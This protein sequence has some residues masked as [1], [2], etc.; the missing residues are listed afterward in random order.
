MV[1]VAEA[2]EAVTATDGAAD[3]LGV[4][5]AIADAE[6]A[7]VGAGLLDG[8]PDAVEDPQPATTIAAPA[9]MPISVR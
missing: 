2:G 8:L 4:A 5:A 6:G 7:V 9:T 1:G 3:A